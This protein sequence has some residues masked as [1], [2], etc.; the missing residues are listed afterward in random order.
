MSK[1]VDVP[2]IPL[3]DFFERREIQ[4]RSIR[5]EAWVAVRSLTLEQ[6]R[7]AYPYRPVSKYAESRF[8]GNHLCDDTCMLLNAFAV[9]CTMCQAPTKT[10]YLWHEV[11]P[12]CDGCS[13]LN[14]TNPHASV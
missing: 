12:D 1:E 9:R 2:P 3:A 10:E 11:C 4:R 6:A 14:G 13:E 5:G 7:Q 8:G